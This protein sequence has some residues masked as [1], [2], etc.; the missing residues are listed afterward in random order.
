MS[1]APNYQN[2]IQ[3]RIAAFAD[4]IKKLAITAA[5]GAVADALGGKP[6]TRERAVART[7]RTTKPPRAVAQER[8]PER[9]DVG[10]SSYDVDDDAPP[11]EAPEPRGG[12]RPPEVLAQMQTVLLRY[13]QQHPGERLEEIADGLGT[14]RP[15]LAWPMKKLL[16]SRAV[17]SRG[18]KRTRQYFP[19]K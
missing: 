16:A 8:A 18:D 17:K 2:Q 1:T 4:D 10:H 3:D 9:S 11:P 19:A 5:M 12:K 6:A 7:R 14:S 15:T 13:I